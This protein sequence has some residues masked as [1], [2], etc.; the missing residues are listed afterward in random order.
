MNA[1]ITKSQAAALALVSLTNDVLTLLISHKNLP[2]AKTWKPDGTIEPYSKAK[3]FK[4]QQLS[5][6]NIRELSELL[7]R[8]EKRPTGCIIRGKYVGDKLAEER[9]EGEFVPGQVL[10]R[11]VVFD[12][13]PLHTILIEVDEYEPILTD[14]NTDPVASILEYITTHL[15]EPFH[16]ASYHWQLSSSAGHPTKQGKLNVHLWFWLATPRTSAE[17]KAWAKAIDL[18]ADHS[19]LDP[20]QIHYTSKPIFEEGQIDPIPVR[21]GFE[22]GKQD[23]VVLDID[24]AILK[25]AEKPIR[26]KSDSPQIPREEDEV[27]HWLCENWSVLEKSYDGTKLYITCPFEDQHTTESCPS[28]TA[29]FLAGTGGYTQG[30]FDCKHSHCSERKD[31]DFLDAVG[32][33]AADFENLQSQIGNKG[34]VWDRPID[35]SRMLCTAPGP[36]EWLIHDRIQ[37]GRGIL[38]TGVGGSSKTRVMYHMAIGA[39]IGRLPWDWPIEKIGKSV[40]ILTEDTE[41]D[42]HRTLWSTCKAMELNDEEIEKVKQSVFIYTLA[43]VDCRLLSFDSKRVLEPSSMLKELE[44]KIRSLEDVVFVGLDPALSLS[45]GDELD[46]GHQRTLGKMADDLAVHTGAAV[47]LVSHASKASLGRE[48]LDSHNSRGGGAITDAVRGEF[49]MRTMTTKEANSAGIDDIEERKRHVQLVATKGNHLPPSAYVPVWL[50]RG[51]YGCLSTADLVFGKKQQNQLSAKDQAIFN[52]LTEMPNGCGLSEWRDKCIAGGLIPPGN[53][54][55]Q[56]KSMQRCVD[57]L[58]ERGLITS[59]KRGF[60]IVSPCEDE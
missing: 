29:Y 19:V 55:A 26:E 28:S 45:P 15:P 5:V 13:Q 18:K 57:R 10:R 2:L 9:L 22:P 50:R 40:L 54:D 7:I 44:T 33:I 23:E 1:L 47:M 36:I 51:E 3:N 21:S 39:A 49:A 31:S 41:G 59:P 30:H 14:P 6:K 56:D 48:E 25:K 16:D 34:T 17:L 8:L 12:D 60:Y 52:V 46:Q 37:L 4:Y 35:I 20:I 43:G 42:A 11:K 27:A 58:K 32:Y 53:S 38:L 24:P